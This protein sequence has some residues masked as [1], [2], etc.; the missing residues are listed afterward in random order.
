MHLYTGAVALF[1]ASLRRALGTGVAIVVLVTADVSPADLLVFRGMGVRVQVVESLTSVAAGDDK[2]P[3]GWRSLNDHGF[4][5]MLTKLALWSL[6]E[7]DQVA[8]YDAD[9][10]ILA[11]DVGGVFDA[12]GE[13]ALCA[14]TDEWLNNHA[15][16]PNEATGEVAFMRVPTRGYFNAGFLVC[17]PPVAAMPHW[18]VD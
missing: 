9:H 15:F 4:H 8:Y 6:V 1:V 7:F 5:R 17:A 11:A 3:N 18:L 12:C 16:A 13:A 2:V 14:T 10:V